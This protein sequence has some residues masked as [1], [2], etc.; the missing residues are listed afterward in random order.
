MYVMR[1]PLSTKALITATITLLVNVAAGTWAAL[2]RPIVSTNGV[3]GTSG[4]DGNPE[5]LFV[6]K[7]HP[8]IW[9]TILYIAQFVSIYFLF[10]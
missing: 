9:V 1:S 8:F 6:T 5:E 10:Y 7:I 2:Q 4:A 3:F